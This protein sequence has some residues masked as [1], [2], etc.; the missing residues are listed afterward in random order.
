MQFAVGEKMVSVLGLAL[1]P[2]ALWTPPPPVLLVPGTLMPVRVE[3]DGWLRPVDELRRAGAHPWW[4]VAPVGVAPWSAPATPAPTSDLV[5]PQVRLPRARGAPVRRFHA[6][7]RGPAVVWVGT[8]WV[9]WTL[10][11]NAPNPTEHPAPIRLPSPPEADRALSESLADLNVLLARE[12]GDGARL[13]ALD[14][15]VG[16]IPWTPRRPTVRRALA[17]RAAATG[18]GRG[19]VDG[20]KRQELRAA[21]YLVLAERAKP[22]RH[23]FGRSWA[24]GADGKQAALVPEQ[25]APPAFWRWFCDEVRK[26]AEASLLGEPYPGSSGR[27]EDRRVLPGAC[28]LREEWAAS[29]T[30]GTDA[31]VDPLDLLLAAERRREAEAWWQLAQ[32]EATPRQRQLLRALADLHAF[33]EDGG[34]AGAIASGG[35]GGDDVPALARAAERV[36]MAPSTARVQWK[37]LR[38]RLRAAYA[39]PAPVPHGGARA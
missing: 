23:R 14:R 31:A 27:A 18:A 32:E 10:P 28:R 22:Q 13:P 12:A 29:L 1:A 5:V 25:L 34:R 6:R 7:L 20:V 15:T 38:D 33:S 19:G 26:A 3:L 24:T 11:D 21:V 4:H 8:P 16:R 37:R 36:G 30:A 17:E 39:G 2:K 9:P 35:Q